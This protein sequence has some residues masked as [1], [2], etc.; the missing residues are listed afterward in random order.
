MTLWSVLAGSGQGVTIQIG[1]NIWHFGLNIILYIIVAAVVGVLAEL[2][3]GW[4]LPFG[5]IGAIILGALGAWLLT[6]VIQIN[7][8]GDIYLWGV[9]LI[10][11]LIGAIIL[12]GIWHLLT[13]G[14]RRRGRAY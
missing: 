6:S 13:G 3:V 7:G 5:I 12:I 1:N 8:I 9:P 11:A 14:L 4:R 2:I 10:R